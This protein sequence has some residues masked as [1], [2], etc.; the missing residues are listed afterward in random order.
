MRLLYDVEASHCGQRIA[1]MR[2]HQAPFKSARRPQRAGVSAG[3]RWHAC[4]AANKQTDLRAPTRTAAG[5][6]KSLCYALVPAVRPGVV[7]VVS[8]LIALMQDQTQVRPRGCLCHRVAHLVCDC[9]DHGIPI[10]QE[11]TGQSRFSVKSS[12]LLPPA[13][14]SM[15]AV[16]ASPRPTRRLSVIHAERGRPPPPAG[17]LAAAQAH[18]AGRAGEGQ[19]GQGSARVAAWAQHIPACRY[20]PPCWLRSRR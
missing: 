19:R 7:L 9:E 5:G 11:P 16:A 2:R 3:Q 10:G 15:P 13:S 6:G 8:P 4:C 14:L 18:H 20:Q 17:R 1:T 12:L